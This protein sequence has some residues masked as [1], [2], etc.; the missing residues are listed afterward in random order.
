M[1]D[2][3]NEFENLVRDVRFD[4]KPDYNHR[5]KLEQNLLAVLSKQSRHKT[6]ASNIWRIIMRNRIIQYAAAAVVLI[7]IIMG[8]I[9]LGKPIGANVAFAAAMDKI[10]RA[11][12][13]S[14]TQIFEID[15]G[16]GEQSGKYLSK[17]KMMFKEPD[18]E[19]H[20]QLTS[21]WPRYIGEIT[22]TR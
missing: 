2:R 5:K 4:D 3:E 22:I 6:Q 21:P 11:G 17:Q 15:Y 8:V 10:R 7:A 12:T 9:E 18:R 1:T 16:D 13:F 14:C 20:E 19:R